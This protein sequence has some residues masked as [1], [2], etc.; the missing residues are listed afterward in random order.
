MVPHALARGS[1]VFG[2]RKR[3][4]AAAEA[5]REA[6][7]RALF[8]RLAERPE[9]ICPFLGLEGERTGYVD[10]VSDE[11]RCFAFGDPAPLSAEQ[12]TRVC[13]ERGYG[14]CPRYLR[15]VLVIPTEE[16]EALR[17]ARSAPAAV[18]PVPPARV[19]PRKRRRA[20]L[21][22]VLTLLLL[23]GAGGAGAW[24]LLSGG[25]IAAP[26]ESPTPSASAS[27]VPS[28]T[29]E[30]TEAVTPSDEPSPA[31][32]ESPAPTRTPDPTPLPADVFAFYEVQVDPGDYVLYEVNGAGEIVG[33]RDATFSDRS[34]A[35]VELIDAPNGQR[36][37]RTTEGDYAGLSYVFPNSG[38]FEIWAVYRRADGGRSSEPLP[39]DQ[40]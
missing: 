40:L 19:A 29:P 21:L 8:A 30:P 28:A 1:A 35:T 33:T 13:Q 10:G 23:V 4:D 18:S 5:A 34:Q 31:A 2:R 14:N 16:L 12:Q 11:H 39:E 3:E 22:A 32:T 27:V 17:R 15:G 38:D 36:H 7:R 25:L 26:L 20:P 24:A 9:H 6:G 37:W